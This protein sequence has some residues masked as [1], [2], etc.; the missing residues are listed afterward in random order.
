M[1]FQGFTGG[2]TFQFV[3]NIN[4]RFGSG[5]AQ[6][7]ASELS[8]LGVSKPFVMI[9]PGVFEGG[10]AAPI[11]KALDTGGIAARVFTDI[12]SNPADVTIE[13]AF[14]V[15]QKSDC[16]SVI[17]IGGGSAMDSAKGVGLLMTNGGAIADYDGMN[18]VKRD[19]PPVI[20][21]PTTAGTGSEVTANAA[22]TRA[23]DHYKMSLRSPRLL[24]KLAII[25]P[26]LLR[27]LPRGAAAASG[28]D[29]L[30]HAIEGYLS[31]RASPLSDVFALQAMNLLA[32]NVRAFVANPENLEAASSMAL[33]SML[34]GLV[35]SNT[36]TGNDHALAR[37]IGGLCD[38]AHGVATAMLLPHVMSFN[39]SAR[40]ERYV[41]IAKAIG[42]QGQG[43]P[44]DV[45][46]RAID[47]VRQ[48]LADLDLPTRLRDIGVVQ[49]RLPE[50]VEVAIKNVG[51]NPRRTSPHDLAAILSAVY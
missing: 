20:A 47:E 46:A 39:A 38:V 23:S 45:A 42:V 40:P 43:S 22:V 18:K 8:A 36:G 10:V 37:A 19:L 15:A 51:P 34:A 14:G 41:E 11:L 49:E 1:T 24:P 32:A 17:G 4:L 27:T 16:D 13:R 6:T 50:V 9:D 25:D 7:L 21:V 31:V 48:L 3:A 26:L 29:A 12:E 5:T 44:R 2:G 35:V 30:T 33:G 28:L